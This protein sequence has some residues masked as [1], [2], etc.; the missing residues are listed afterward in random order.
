MDL[1]DVSYLDG[2]TET[3][4]RLEEDGAFLVTRNRA[5]QRNVMTIG[6]GNVARIWGLPIFTVLVR[7]TRHTFS[8]IEDSGEFAVC[9]PGPG[10]LTDALAICGSESGRNRDKFEQCGLSTAPGSAL[11][12][13]LIE[14]CRWFY[15]CRVVYKQAMDP[16]HLDGSIVDKY[17]PARDFHTVYHGQILASRAR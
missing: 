14:S 4:R 11:A 7:P 13:P 16:R 9:V 12:V 10:E 8:L 2:V 5:G 17:Y 15:E 3:L 6:W 1:T